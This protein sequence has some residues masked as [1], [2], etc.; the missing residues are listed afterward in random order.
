MALSAPGRSNPRFALALGVAG[1]QPER[2]ER[3]KTGQRHVDEEHRLPAERLR[4]HA[5]EQHADHQ[6]GRPR[7]A[8]HRQRAV[9]LA[10]FG[11]RGVDQRQGGGKDE[12]APEPL[13]RA[14]DEQ[15]LGY[16]SRAPGQRGTERTARA[17]RRRP[18]GGRAGRRRDRRAAGIR[19]T[20]P[21]RR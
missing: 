15:D 19:R 3:G 11:E 8:P 10:A 13:R 12:R 4:E 5:A 20:P 9:A 18:G 14:G 1:D 21:H 17:R 6:P 2:R 16:R 7:A